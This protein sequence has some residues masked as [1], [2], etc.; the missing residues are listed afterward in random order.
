MYVHTMNLWV[1]CFLLYA[2]DGLERFQDQTCASIAVFRWYLL[3]DVTLVNGKRC[4]GNAPHLRWQQGAPGELPNDG[5]VR[6]V[7]PVNSGRVDARA[8]LMYASSDDEDDDGN[9]YPNVGNSDYSDSSDDEYVAELLK[10]EPGNAT[11]SPPSGPQQVVVPPKVVRPT[12]P[13]RPRGPSTDTSGNGATLVSP[14]GSARACVER[15]VCCCVR[16]M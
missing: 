14:P 15:V 7:V 3:L 8:T 12:A 11:R 1:V 16:V 10:G 6:R 5:V 9:G 2:S 4:F 13:L